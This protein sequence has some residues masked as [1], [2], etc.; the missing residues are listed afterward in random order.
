MNRGCEHRWRASRRAARALVDLLAE[1]F[2]HSSRSEWREEIRSGRITI[3]GIP[4]TPEQLVHGGEELVWR[5]RPWREPDAPTEIGI[6]HDDGDLVVVSKPAG[7]PTL[8]GGGYFENTLLRRI[9]AR[10]PG[11]RPVHRLGRHTSGVVL[12]AADPAI[13]RE[14]SRRFARGEVEREYLAWAAGDPARDRFEVDVPVGPVAYGPTGTVYAASRSGKAARTEIAVLARRGTSFTARV[15]IFNGRP[16][17]IRIHLA[18]A[19]HPL[20]GEPLYGRHGV[21]IPGGRAV[22]GDP[23]YLLHARRVEIAHPRRRVRVGF[24]IPPPPSFQGLTVSS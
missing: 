23:G 12:C 1:E 24:E 2:P 6:V 14:L 9:A 17:Q 20:V 10:V 16:H 7:L 11:A 19:G 5:R 3:G 13:R 22:P 18:W 4:G 21:P 8:P 15:R